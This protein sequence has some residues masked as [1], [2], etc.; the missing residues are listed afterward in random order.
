MQNG[1]VNLFPKAKARYRFINRGKH[2]F[3]AGFAEE[4]RKSVA[5]MAGLKLSKEE[6][7]YLAVTCPYLSPVY[8]DFLQAIVITLM[9]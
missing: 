5:A 1:V 7:D 2:A 6:K 9:K 8:L 4:L 3:P